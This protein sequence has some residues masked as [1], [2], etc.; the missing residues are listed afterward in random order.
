MLDYE[1]K[2]NSV[3]FINHSLYFHVLVN[4]NNSNFR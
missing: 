4:A 1:S 3:V 2:V